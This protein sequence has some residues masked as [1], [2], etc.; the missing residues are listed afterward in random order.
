MGESIDLFFCFQIFFRF[1]CPVA[2]PRQ[3]QKSFFIPSPHAD[4]SKNHFSFRRRTPTTPKIIFHPVAARRRLQKSFFT[5][6][7]H[8]DDLKSQ[9]WHIVET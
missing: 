6:S 5:P 8:A 9:H 4:N 3:S 1:F 2:T 7:A